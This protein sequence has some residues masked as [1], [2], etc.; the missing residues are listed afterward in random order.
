MKSIKIEEC[1]TD[2]DLNEISDLA[3]EIWH[4]CYSNILSNEQI[5]Y[6]FQKFQSVDA[7]QDQIKHQQYHYHKVYE[8]EELIGYIGLQN[9]PDRLF[10]SKFYLKEDFRNQHYASKMFEYVKQQAD[11]YC[12]LAIYL[13]CN[14]KNIHSLDVFEK[15]GFQ[16]IDSV[17]TDIGQ[18]Y[19]TDDYL[20]EY[21]MNK[22]H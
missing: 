8:K 4:E 10:L 16:W 19:I 21:R 18:G 13:M 2:Q 15:F 9:Q 7:M 5:D 11:K 14:K 3:N 6:M 1:K 17:Q 22:I 12:Y 20:L